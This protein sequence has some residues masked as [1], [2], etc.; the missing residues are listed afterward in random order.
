MP[1]K[2][3]NARSLPART[4]VH[5]GEVLAAEFLD[6]LGMSQYRLARAIRVPPRRLNEIVHG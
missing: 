3:S 2:K 4:A 1:T 5:P 6:E